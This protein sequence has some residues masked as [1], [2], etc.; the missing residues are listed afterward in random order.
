MQR[1]AWA[2]YRNSSWCWDVIHALVHTH[3]IRYVS[4]CESPG[5]SCG[6]LT[7][8]ARACS[9]AGMFSPRRCHSICLPCQRNALWQKK[10]VWRGSA[11][12]LRVTD[13]DNREP[14]VAVL[15]LQEN[16]C[17]QDADPQRLVPESSALIW[18]E[19]EIPGCRAD[20]NRGL[21]YHKQP[22]LFQNAVSH[23]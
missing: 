8:Q 12:W 2:G 5:S 18:I 16:I 10:K 15:T 19:I 21:L 6:L 1:H 17:M 20:K 9:S 11:A 22:C 13:G 23:F 4:Q 3:P 14:V 7:E